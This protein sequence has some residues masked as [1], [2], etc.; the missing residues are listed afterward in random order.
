MFMLE[1]DYVENWAYSDNVFN[2]NEC[3]KIIDIGKSL[4]LQD[5]FV[6]DNKINKDIRDSKVS[7]I[8]PNDNTH[9][10]F[11]RVTAAIKYLNN[12]FFKFD[13]FGLA[14][15]FQFTEYAAPGNFYGMHIDKIFLGAVRKLSITIQLS[16]PNDYV[17]GE[18]AIMLDKDP[19]ILPKEY[20][21]LVCFPSYVLHE[22]RPVT[23][24]TRYSLVAWVTGKPFK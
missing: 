9:W 10:I 20:G 8:Y 6:H 11:E 19:I 13:L 1:S 5:A 18:L 14:E 12:N 24:G 15:G 23:E 4:I 21:K 7:W 22:V 16:D 2:S 17:G 3:K